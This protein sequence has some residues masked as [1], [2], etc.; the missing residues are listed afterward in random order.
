VSEPRTPRDDA[1]AALEAYR[2][3]GETH[4]DEVVDAFVQRVENRLA[5]RTTHQP[6]RRSGATDAGAVVLGVCSLVF[7][8]PLIAIAADSG[9]LAV[10]AVAVLLIALN[11]LYHA[12]T[13]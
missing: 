5:A 13:R 10:L 12:R 3:V 2:E 4:A 1:R 7:A 9:G 11:A 8:I 6:S